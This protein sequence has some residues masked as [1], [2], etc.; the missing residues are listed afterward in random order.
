MNSTNTLTG[1]DARM[2]FII[3]FIIAI[4]LPWNSGDLPASGTLVD[5]DSYMRLVELERFW[6]GGGWFD[7]SNMRMNAPEGVTLHW[8]RPMDL[9]LI[10]LAAPL[11]LV[12][13]AKQAFYWSGYFISPL[14]L[15]LTGWAVFAGSAASGRPHA[16]LLA[17]AMIL[18]ATDT[19][20]CA[21]GRPLLLLLDDPAAE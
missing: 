4:F 15:L 6:N 19:A 9:I 2:I 20:Q 10:T 3:W 7:H 17:S 5:T 21:L 18:A 8:T 12:M 13:E 16:G 1:R 14:F 11:M